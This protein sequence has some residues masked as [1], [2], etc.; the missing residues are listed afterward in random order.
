MKTWGTGRLGLWTIGYRQSAGTGIMLS[1]DPT[2]WL[3]S[4]GVGKLYGGGIGWA[5]R[6][7]RTAEF[8]WQFPRGK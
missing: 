8:T 5:Y 7:A 1:V 4:A 6:K 3:L 2:G